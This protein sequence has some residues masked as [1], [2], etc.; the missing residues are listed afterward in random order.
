MYLHCLRPCSQLYDVSPDTEDLVWRCPISTI[1]EELGWLFL[2]LPS[3][4]E[5]V[6]VSPISTDTEELG[7]L[8]P[9]LTDAKE[10]VWLCPM[11]THTKKLGWCCHMYH[12]LAAKF[13][14]ISAWGLRKPTFTCLTQHA[15]N[16]WIIFGKIQVP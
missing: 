16:K 5:L 3:T 8:Y 11:L 1:T 14:A 13:D 2:A 15:D 12:I 9:I 4:D 10:L 7:C 6:W